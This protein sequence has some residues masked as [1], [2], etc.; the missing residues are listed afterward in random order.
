M[1]F[2]KNHMSNSKQSF[3]FNLKDIF[4]GYVK[5]WYWFALSLIVFLGIAFIYLRYTI[6]LYNVSATIAISAEDNISESGFEAFKEL[7]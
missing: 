2:D 4:I 1:D 6:P 5:K 3:N 7:D